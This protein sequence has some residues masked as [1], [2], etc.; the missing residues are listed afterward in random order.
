MPMPTRP[1]STTT[2]TARRTKPARPATTLEVAAL[3]KK[4]L[5]TIAQEPLYYTD[6]AERFASYDFRTVA[7]ALGHLHA[8]E[9]LWQDPRG[10]MCVRGS[11]RGQP[12]R[13][14]VTAS[15][16]VDR[17]RRIRRSCALASR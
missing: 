15:A 17:I 7:R 11:V 3:A 10:K 14:S 5:E 4:I 2:S 1:R 8:T 13:R 6:I 12:P 16:N 9:K